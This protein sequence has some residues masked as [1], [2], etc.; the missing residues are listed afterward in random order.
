MVEIDEEV[1][2]FYPE[3]PTFYKPTLMFTDKKE[4]KGAYKLSTISVWWSQFP[5]FPCN[6]RCVEIIVKK[7]SS[8][9]SELSGAERLTG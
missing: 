4:L 2:Q 3:H 8:P 9:G 6:V 1:Q 7:K 5:C